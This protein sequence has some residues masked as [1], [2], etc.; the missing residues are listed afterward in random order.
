MIMPTRQLHPG[1]VEAGYVTQ[2]LW[3]QRLLTEWA[4]PPGG[5]AHPA[6]IDGDVTVDYG[7]L[8]RRRDAVAYGLSRRGVHPGAVV[9]VEL[10]NWW[11]ASVIMHATLAL[12]GVVNPVVPIYR[13][14][15]VGFIV[16]QSGAAAVFVPHRFRGFDY[17]AMLGRLLPELPTRPL[18]VVVRAQGPLPDGFIDFEELLAE[19]SAQLPDP[20]AR[21]SDICL[22]LYTSGTTAEA[23]G[24]LHSH[25]TLRYENRSM[26][27]LLGIT[28]TDTIFMASPVTHITGFLYA[29][30]LPPMLGSTVV[31]LDVW[32]PEVAADLIEAHECRF[33]LGAT[34]FLQ[35][36]VDAYR[37][38]H[39]RSALRVFPCGGADVPPELVRQG[40]SVLGCA[41][42]RVYG[43][44]EFPTYSCSGPVA[45]EWT[46][47]ETDGPPIGPVQHRIDGPDGQP[48][49]L[50]VRGPELFLG[51]LNPQLNL[52]A[53]TPDGWF[54]TGDLA[55]EDRGAIT[56]RGRSKD[57]IIRGGENISAKQIEDCLYQHPSVREV[58]VVAMPDA[59]MGEKG[60]AFV[61]PE[62]EPPS[63]EVLC[64]FL[65]AARIAR[66][67]FPEHLE[68]VDELPKTASGKV[69]KYVLRQRVAGR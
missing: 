55:T 56:I 63:L 20:G 59:R 6:I 24:V 68:I 19:Q 9:T 52:D 44:S 41:V 69:Q 32:D 37:R 10:P 48:G 7:E 31:Y 33:T 14:A 50:L 17:V 11:E 42:T 53:F 35:G 43:S 2:G 36:L 30:L 61:V 51:Y 3:D 21:S 39:H 8:R 66:Q 64:A 46:A 13:D 5:D 29:I 1:G 45:D 67:K 27:D 23:K 60:C 40:R 4:S 58:A 34:P 12:A 49:E 57:I 28:A 54:R 26:V 38:R 16:R 22:L 47:A 18:I 62:G 25:D 15:E 65:E